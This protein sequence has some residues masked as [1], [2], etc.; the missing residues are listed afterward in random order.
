MIGIRR[1][2]LMHYVDRIKRGKPF[3]FVRYGEGEIK[4]MIPGLPI[5]G[6]HKS[7]MGEHYDN[8]CRELI[9]TV[10]KYH[11]SDRYVM[12][13]QH[14]WHFKQTGKLGIVNRWFAANVPTTIRW[15]YAGIFR[16][17]TMNGNFYPMIDAMRRQPLPPV[18]VGPERIAPLVRRFGAK[19]IITKTR[20]AWQQRELY[21]E[22]ILGLGKPAFISFSASFCAKW[23]IHQLWSIIGEHSYLIDFGSLWDGYCG[24][25]GRPYHPKMTKKLINRNLGVKK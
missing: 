8:L 21:K 23:L 18:F 3:A 6:T 11:Q 15:A 25:R 5:K 19:H 10:T 2:G 1:P 20:W 4:W 22:Q 9:G 14:L 16:D 24:I 13:L 12:A 7:L 17:A